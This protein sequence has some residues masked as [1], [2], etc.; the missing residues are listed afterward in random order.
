MRT[1]GESGVAV[2]V[3][4]DS[5]VW[6]EEVERL[7]PDGL[8]RRQAERARKAIE[9]DR[10]GLAWK[11]C[12][13]EGP[14]GTKLA[15]CVKLYVPLGQEGA[16]AAP[17]GFVFR[18]NRVE[19]GLALR[20]VAFGERHPTNLRTRSVYERAHRRLHGRYP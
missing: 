19:G 10:S 11:P 16:S 13:A 3:E 20:M 9:A 1:S 17:Y 18:L 8:A 7:R 2:R 12:Q 6:A 15:R 5:E 14:Q 4:I